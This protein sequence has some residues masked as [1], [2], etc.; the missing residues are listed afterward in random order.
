MELPFHLRALPPEALDVLR[1]Y[2]KQSLSIAHAEEIMDGVGLSER[3]FGKVIRRL[4]TKGYLQMDSDQAYR[5]SDQGQEAV[6]TLAE[7]DSDS[8]LV[9]TEVKSKAE[10]KV[11]RRLVLVTPRSFVAGS[12]ADIHIGF[13]PASNGQNLN[14]TAE[15]VLR[16]AVINGELARPQEAAFELD[17]QSAHHTFK[18]TPGSFNRMRIKV[19]AFQLGPN[20]DDIAVAGGMYVDADVAASAAVPTPVAYGANVTLTRPE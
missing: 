7:Y 12:P 2:H 20:P 3:I 9:K 8:P 1:F 6:E 14:G 11:A 19:Q 4:V 18:V 10:E 17:N 5:L 13:H 15:V 16:V